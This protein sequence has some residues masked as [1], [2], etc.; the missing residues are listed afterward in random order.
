MA[1]RMMRRISILIFSIF[2][3]ISALHSQ[4]I[5]DESSTKA[6]VFHGDL[7]WNPES[8]IVS[9]D[10]GITV[11]Y[12]NI[13]VSADS[14][15]AFLKTKT[16][17]F[18]GNVKLANDKGSVY[19]D[20][21][22]YNIQSDNW[23]FNNGKSELLPRIF[24]Y[25]L[26]SSVFIKGDKL[27][28]SQDIISVQNGSVTTC[29][30]EKPHYYF[31][32]K[33]MVIHPGMRII[34]H[35]AQMIVNNKRLFSIGKLII[36]IKRTDYQLIP[37]IGS[38]ND[39]GYYVKLSYPY[40][41]TEQNTGIL[42]LDLMTNKG[43][44]LGANHSYSIK[45]AAGMAALYYLNDKSINGTNITGDFRHN[46]YIGNVELDVLSNYRQNSY[47]Y[48]PATKYYNT[49][50]NLAHSTDKSN[51]ALSLR[52]RID[53]SITKSTEESIT[54][55]QMQILNPRL[56]ADFSID[57]QS[58]KYSEMPSPDKELNANIDIVQR[59]DKY[60]LRLNAA[61][62]FDLDGNSYKGDDQFSGL[63]KLPELTFE[64]DSIRSEKSSLLGL[65]YKL[66]VSAGHY[67]EMPSD[68]SKGR[69]LLQVEIPEKPID[70]SS[71]S[72]IDFSA[73]YRQT[74]YDDDMAQY[75]L[76]FKSLMTTRYSEYLKSR[77][78]WSYKQPYGYSPFRFDYTGRYNYARAILD[79]QDN[80]RLRFSLSSGYDFGS[81]NYSWQDISLKLTAFQNRNFSYALSGGYDLNEGKWKT[82]TSQIKL[83]VPRRIVLELGTKYN[84]EDGKIDI[85]RGILDLYA[86]KKWRIQGIAGW[87][88]LS[89]EYD[90]NALRITRDLHCWEASVTFTDESGFR[91]DK[92]INLELRIKAFPYRDR[93]GMGQYGQ[94]VDTSMGE[95]FY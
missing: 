5:P 31:Y 33:K 13:Q 26:S 38:S 84:M 57:M 76:K 41:S 18:A 50:I 78:G 90:Y 82:F 14:M 70:I 74:F 39:E 58:Y 60:D 81:K 30:L 77:I 21:L 36:P 16:I 53:S 93:F 55:R 10:S 7:R 89:K 79:Y 17:E 37:Q 64:T 28:S 2:I 83:N 63:E 11:E 88:G 61:K 69:F 9:A 6:V 66:T 80:N 42:K 71:N 4:E 3:I 22:S 94:L 48:F 25:Y 86:D 29:D 46:Q 12:E 95:Y 19:G 24:N 1:R 32:V 85:M 34:A 87:N 62:R 45:N 72:Q 91:N 67:H 47:L 35:N 65:P 59:T 49:Q 52:R 23:S 73:G 54:F 92:T 8:E 43:V 40:T 68:V 75:V 20:R 44:G 27:E 15:T 56:N 51:S